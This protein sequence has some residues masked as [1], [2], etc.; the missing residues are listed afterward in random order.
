MEKDLTVDFQNQLEI[1]KK[2]Y[3]NKIEIINNILFKI[4][5][6]D[7]IS[8]VLDKVSWAFNIKNSNK[9]SELFDSL[10]KRLN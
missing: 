7:I 2:D 4:Q 10:T 5:I 9:I 1:Q 3:Q 8:L 6:R